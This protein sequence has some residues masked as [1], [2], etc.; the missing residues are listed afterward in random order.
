LL[1]RANAGTIVTITDSSL[2]EPAQ[3][4][5]ALA[6]F[7]RAVP[8]WQAPSSFAEFEAHTARASA[9]QFAAALDQAMQ[10]AE[11]KP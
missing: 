10:H 6:D 2:A 3:I 11:V 9:Q 1:V 8:S 5:A 7:L 4:A